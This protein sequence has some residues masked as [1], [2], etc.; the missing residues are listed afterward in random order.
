MVAVVTVKLAPAELMMSF[1]TSKRGQANVAM[2]NYKFYEVRP[3]FAVD[4]DGEDAAEEVFDLTNNPNRQDER[5]QLYGR[6]RSLSVG[7]IVE[8]DGVNYLCKSTGWEAIE[9]TA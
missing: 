1:Y 6:G 5:V 2:D 9:E 8:V 4:A 3:C 7:D